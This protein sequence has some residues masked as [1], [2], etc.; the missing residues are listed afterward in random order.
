MHLFKDM[1]KDTYRE[2]KKDLDMQE[3]MNLAFIKGL[4]VTSG[5]AMKE[6]G[7][8]T[9]EFAVPEVIPTEK[10]KKYKKKMKIHGS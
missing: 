4:P 2:S 8:E 5:T 3:K 6:L 9:E 7:R 10:I 1:F